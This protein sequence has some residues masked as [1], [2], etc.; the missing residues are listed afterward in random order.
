[1]GEYIVDFVCL[2]RKLVI[3]IDGKYHDTP[4][5]QEEDATRSRNLETYGVRI[6]RFTNEQ[7]LFELDQTI[8]AIKQEL[9]K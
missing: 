6:I 3:E 9:N 2:T 1:M 7:V 5:Q 8:E 4:K